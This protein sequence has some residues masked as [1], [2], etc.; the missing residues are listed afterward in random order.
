MSMTGP[1]SRRKTGMWVALA[2]AVVVALGLFGGAGAD[3]TDSSALRSEVPVP[4]EGTI[5]VRVLG[6]VL[7]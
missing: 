2:I 6:P 5:V 4:S 1:E 7:Y 3:V